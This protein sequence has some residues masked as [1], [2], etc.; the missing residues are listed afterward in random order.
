MDGLPH[1]PIRQ[2]VHKNAADDRKDPY[3]RFPAQTKSAYLQG[4][5]WWFRI[6]R[7]VPYECMPAG[8]FLPALN[9]RKSLLRLPIYG[10]QR[11]APWQKIL[12]RPVQARLHFCCHPLRRTRQNSLHFPRPPSTYRCRPTSRS[13]RI[14]PF[15]PSERRSSCH[16]TCPLFWHHGFRYPPGSPYHPPPDDRSAPLLYRKKRYAKSPLIFL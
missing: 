4:S 10:K 9:S 1:L 11:K 8:S 2:T 7:P 14:L 15:C 16:R 3:S 5:T 12:L 6:F 13:C